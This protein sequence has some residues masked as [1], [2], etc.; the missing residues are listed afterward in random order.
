MSKLRD[1]ED[2]HCVLWV[3]VHELEEKL[4]RTIK[5]FGDRIE[6]LETRAVQAECDHSEIAFREKSVLISACDVV[7]HSYKKV[8]EG[9]GK[10]LK[11]YLTHYGYYKDLS[12][13]QEELLIKRH[14]ED[15]EALRAI[16]KRKKATK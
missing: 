16:E 10:T 6:D 14:A 1:L 13:H 4:K 5:Q 11:I 3:E 15:T 9:C 7:N 12:E 8:C 2:R